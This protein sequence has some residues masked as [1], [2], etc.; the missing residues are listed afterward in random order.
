[1]ARSTC[2]TRGKAEDDEHIARTCAG[3]NENGD[4]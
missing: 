3:R 2:E 4:L 1:M